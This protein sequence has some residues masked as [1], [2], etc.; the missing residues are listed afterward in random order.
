MATANRWLLGAVAG[1]VVLQL[2]VV[3]AAPLQ[4][5]FDTAPLSLAELAV[6]LAVSSL[7]F[8]VVETEK[9]WQRRRR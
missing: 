8:V 4:E 7:L 2:A 1:S 5:L 3:Y 9:W 6:T